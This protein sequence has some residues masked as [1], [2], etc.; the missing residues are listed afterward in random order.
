MDDYDYSREGRMWEDETRKMKRKKENK[1]YETG[2][3]EVWV[4]YKC[5]TPGN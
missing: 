2:L 1:Q 3:G 4:Y 5:I